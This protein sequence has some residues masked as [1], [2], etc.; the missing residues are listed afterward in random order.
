M[1]LWENTIQFRF[2]VW[3]LSHVIDTLGWRQHAVLRQHKLEPIDL[4][5]LL[6]AGRHGR[7]SFDDIR[8]DTRM[9][10]HSISRA[11]SRLVKRGLGTVQSKE[12]DRRRREFHIKKRGRDLLERTETLTA[13]A[14]RRDIGVQEEY[15][16]R[17]YEFTVHLW[18]LT[19]FLPEAGCGNDDYLFPTDI[20]PD[21]EEGG[22]MADPFRDLV[23]QLRARRRVSSQGHNLVP[24]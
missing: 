12:S 7:V 19:G 3:S 13:K 23:E 20:A 16:K 8:R 2:L 5:L 6:R 14:V 18:Q 4:S 9:P 1:M 11:A 21:E 15:S 10:S 22:P 17:Y 24:D